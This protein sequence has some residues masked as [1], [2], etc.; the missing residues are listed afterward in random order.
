MPFFGTQTKPSP[1]WFRVQ[2]LFV[3]S[4]MLKT[5]NLC[6]LFIQ[7]ILDESLEFQP[8]TPPLMR[9]K[10]SLFKGFS[11]RQRAPTYFKLLGL[12]GPASPNE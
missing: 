1:V 12:R 9:V 3:A 5:S 4:Q 10:I 11:I 6:S 2:H 8:P 7:K